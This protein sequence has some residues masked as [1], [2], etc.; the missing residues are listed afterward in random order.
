MENGTFHNRIHNFSFSDDFD[1]TPNVPLPNETWI[2]SS[3]QTMPSDSGLTVRT[4]IAQ[5][6]DLT[7]RVR[8]LLRQM[9][10]LEKDNH[11]LRQE[12]SSIQIQH[13]S[14]AQE[15]AVH[16]EKEKSLLDQIQ[17]LSEDINKF[18]RRF[19]QYLE[20]ESQ[21]ERYKK[22][23]EKVKTQIKP[24]VAELKVYADN[25]ARQMRDLHQE[26]KGKDE[27]ISVLENEILNQ[28]ENSDR[29]RL[30]HQTTE[31]TLLEQF[32]NEKNLLKGEIGQLMTKNHDLE[33]RSERMNEALFTIDHLQ[34]EIL[35]L[36]SEKRGQFED[37]L[38]EK[39]SLQND[40]L[41][42]KNQI[43]NLRIDLDQSQT[44]VQYYKE[45]NHKIRSQM[46]ATE[47]QLSS[48]RHLWTAK[49][50][51]FEKLK[52]QNSSLEKIN[53]EISQRLNQNRQAQSTEPVR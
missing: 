5:N 6:E 44:Q 31:K 36:R 42:M 2:S 49:S 53:L 4:L 3:V 20:M 51:E 37:L 41:Q 7:A 26:I 23:H 40:V 30:S 52:E 10:Q 32:E 48:L 45:E 12:N 11:Q 13:T 16:N 17:S 14:L 28:K 25:L 15:H 33:N 22:Y 47:E 39:S 9:E 38:K 19:P 34:N 24:Y 35:K 29:T 27:K 46:I 21:I 1:S 8:V 43:S 18:K 50:E